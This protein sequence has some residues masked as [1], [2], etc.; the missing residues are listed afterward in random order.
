LALP[1][2]ILFS[3][4]CS[5]SGDVPSGGVYFSYMPERTGGAFI[6]AF[7][8]YRSIEKPI[9]LTG[10]AAYC[11]AF[12]TAIEFCPLLCIA[13]SL[14]TREFTF[15]LYKHGVP[16]FNKFTYPVFFTGTLSDRREYTFF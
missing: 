2:F 1:G 16:L 4:Y 12:F 11:F 10:P 7:R 13:A 3:D 15:F 14:T 6:S 9:V 8:A 5:V